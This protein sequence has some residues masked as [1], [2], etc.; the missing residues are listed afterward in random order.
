ME[1]KQIKEKINEGWIHFRAIIEMMGAPK[2]HL[3]NTIK[4]YV[5]KLK[6]ESK[7]YVVVDEYYAEPKP[8]DKLFTTFVE[9]EMLAKSSE[10]V[11]WFCFDWMPSSVEIIEPETI[12]Y[13][14]QDFT[15]LLNDLQA[16]LHTIDMALKETKARSDIIERNA[17][18]ILKNNILLNL[19][20]GEKELKE[21]SKGTG[22]PEDQL[23][24]FLDNM[25][26]EGRIEKKGLVYKRITKT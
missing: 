23:K 20:D 26:K 3:M 7:D 24:P 2:D 10:H 11:V 9:L 4:S 5:N 12:T 18:I 13:K 8:A 15:S 25:V 19:K 22:I 6:N 21:L 14:S 17:S 16:R 1:P